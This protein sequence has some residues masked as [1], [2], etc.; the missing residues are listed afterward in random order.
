[1]PS[2]SSLIDAALRGDSDSFGELVR[3]H[4]DRLFNAMVHVV[5]NPAEA[6]DVV[7]EA[8]VHAY[9]KL[10]TFERS[11]AFYT[12][13][14][15][16]AFNRAMSRNRRK[17][18]SLSV[19]RQRDEAGAEPAAADDDPAERLLRNERVD[20]I[21][22]GLQCLN[23]EHRAVLVLREI[24]GH[25]YETIASILELELGTVR[26]RLHRARL[27]LRDHL[28]RILRESGLDSD[29]S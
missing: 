19:D 26:S 28:R 4:Q 18:P 15:R 12:W 25:D 8:F 10:S 20:L 1:M 2:E 23:E 27:Q 5:G 3:L 16:I 9:L 11:S 17:R 24:E 21:R 29:V 7:Q 6:E 13:L 14:Y 22:Q